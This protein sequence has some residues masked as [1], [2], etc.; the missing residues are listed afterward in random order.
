MMQYLRLVLRRFIG[1]WMG[2]LLLLFLA[3]QCVFAVR[4]A[5]MAW[6]APS[7]TTFERS[8]QWRLAHSPS[9][10]RWQQEWVDLNHI[11]VHLQRA[12][13]VSEDDLFLQHAGV[14]W[15]ALEKARERNERASAQ[16][17][18]QGRKQSRVVGASTITQQLAKNLFLSGERTWLRK[19]QELIL[20]LMLEALLDK[21]RILEIYLN[22]V[23]WGEG[24]FG[25]Q[26]AAWHYFGKSAADL[27]EWEAARLAVML[28]RPKWFQKNPESLYWAE[29]S[30]VILVRMAGVKTP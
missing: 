4:I 18:R 10:L 11:S 9:P 2:G 15:D 21:R 30:E 20:T 3:L 29:R 23:E 1:P 19:G 25:A 6:V 22:H 17:Q 24:I 12:V 16:A 8:E 27:G 26:A 7:S 14:Q 28:P 13:I 5:T